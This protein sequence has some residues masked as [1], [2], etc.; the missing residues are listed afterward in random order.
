MT[1]HAKYQYLGTFFAAAGIYPNV[2]QTVAWNSNNI[3]GSTK[4]SVGIAM[5]VGFGNLGGVLSGYTY[6]W[7]DAPGYRSGHAILIG[8]LAMSTLL[9]VGMRWWCGAENRRRDGRNEKSGVSGGRKVWG[10]KDMEAERERGDY[11]GF[12]RY[13]L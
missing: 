3:G 13:T 11:A 6:T 7:R 12:F 9:C 1:H 4:R 8:L 2:S 10:R 5:Q